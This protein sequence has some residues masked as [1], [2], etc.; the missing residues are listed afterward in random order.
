MT[1]NKVKSFTIDP[2]NQFIKQ[3][4]SSSI[5]MLAAMVMAMAVA[6]STYAGWYHNLWQTDFGITAGNFSLV[7]PVIYWINDGLMAIFFLVIGLEI[8][9]EIIIG[10]L[11]SMKK[12]M[13]PIVAAMG[14]AI[15]PALVYVAINIKGGDLSGWGIP[16]ATDI[17]FA[18]GV[19]ALLG[20]RVP[21]QL[22]VFITS[23]A[24][25]DDMIAVLVIAIFYSNS[26]AVSYLLYAG[27]VVIALI[28]FNLFKVRSILVYLI[29]G[30]FLWYFFLKSGVH[31]TIA[32]VLLALF[33]P[34]Q[35]KIPLMTYKKSLG[36]FH[37]ELRSC[38]DNPE[39]EIPT[40]C[41]KH[42][43][44]KIIHASLSTYNP[45]SRLE[46]NLHG[47]SAFL[48]MPIFAFANTGVTIGAS[49]FDSIFS[50]VSLGIMLGLVVG[51]PLGIMG[52]VILSV[53]SKLISLPDEITKT[54]VFGASILSGIGL[55]MS[56]F[57]AGMAFPPES[58]DV[59]K[60]AILSASLVAGVAG[61]MVLRR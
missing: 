6:N 57:I 47:I 55:T 32:G 24:V 37:S 29:A 13:L 23:L 45:M 61:Y 2:F 26:I 20:S 54:H 48:I 28:A 3:Q 53:K 35:P 44:N 38:P 11:S 56:I 41:Q 39:S 1:L 4:S 12:A 16:M 52:F 50:P 40:K 15:V 30:V 42:T 43:L 36:I 25:V 10:E 51:K 60:V 7:K 19:M 27:L 31:A 8:K 9:R 5:I 34:S 14:G 49:A 46:Y 21:I 58:V 22:K 33:I 17:A 59:A 18:I